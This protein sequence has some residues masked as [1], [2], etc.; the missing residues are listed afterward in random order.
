[1]A[2]KKDFIIESLQ[3]NSGRLREIFDRY[4]VSNPRLFGSVARGRDDETSDID[5]LV[6][7]GKG[8]SFYDLAD[9]ESEL[10]RVLGFRVDV[11]TP[12][13]LAADVRRNVER[14]LRPLF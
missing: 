2:D 12:G 9:L 8:L 6:D 1:M 13:G 7:P 5:I 4:N 3:L 14:D 10:Q 11:T